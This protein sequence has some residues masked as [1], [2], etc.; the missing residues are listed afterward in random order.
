MSSPQPETSSAG[1]SKDP[2]TFLTQIL[3]SPITIKLNSGA[4]YKGDLQSVDGFMNIA[5]ENAVEYPGGRKW[6]DVFIRGNN[7]LY[8]SQ[9]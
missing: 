1:D 9:D 6:G 8:I 7:V 2:S 5:L 4:H 3:N